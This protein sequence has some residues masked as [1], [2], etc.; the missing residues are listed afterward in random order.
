MVG[1]KRAGVTSDALVVFGATGDLAHKQIFPAL[2]SMTKRGVLNVPV[3][4]VAHSGWNSAQLR[5]RAKDSIE[6]VD[7]GIDDRHAFNSLLSR[8][9]Y[10]DGDWVFVVGPFAG[11]VIAV[12]FA[13]VLRGT[14][15][16]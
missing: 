4:G 3:V 13:R 6:R 5:E 12:G 15:G 7:G 1:S 16:G 2:Y 8:L 11:A 14:G 10:V 9:Q